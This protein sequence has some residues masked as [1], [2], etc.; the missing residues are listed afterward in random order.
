MEL[1]P[2]KKYF[3]TSCVLFKDVDISYKPAEDKSFSSNEIV[4]VE[5]DSKVK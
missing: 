5:L 4:V 2:G 3:H 1:I